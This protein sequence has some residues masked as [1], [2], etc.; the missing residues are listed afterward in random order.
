MQAWI[1]Y[2]AITMKVA[3]KMLKK[4]LHA[5]L[6][7]PL[8]LLLHGVYYIIIFP[9]KIAFLREKPHPSPKTPAVSSWLDHADSDTTIEALRRQF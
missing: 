7:I 9:Y 5:V 3:L 8:T 1:L 2:N 6:S 4:C